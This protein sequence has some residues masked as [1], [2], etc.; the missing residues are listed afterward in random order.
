L[1]PLVARLHSNWLMGRTVSARL[2]RVS[3]VE[4]RLIAAGSSSN[5]TSWVLGTPKW[6]WNFSPW[7]LG[8]WQLGG[9]FQANAGVPFTPGIGGDA[10]GVSSTEPTVDVLNVI[11]GPGCRSLVN[12]GNPNQYVKTQFCDAETTS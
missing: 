2:N 1:V 5:V 4:T 12:A 11:P 6:K 9:V 8:G 10:V 3:P 7:V